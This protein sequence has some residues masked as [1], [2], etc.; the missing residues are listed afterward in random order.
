MFALTVLDHIRL[1]SEHCA[2]NY[3]LHAAAADRLARLAF[4]A[5]IVMATLLAIAV[6]ATIVDLLLTSRYY[7]VAATAAT[8]V[9]AIGFGLYCVFGFEGRV[10]AHRACAQRLWL[11]AERYRSLLTE[12]GEGLVEPP[13]LLTRR[14]GLIADLHAI[15]EHGFAADQRGY[16]AARLAELPA[17]RAA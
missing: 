15:Y 2:R 6:A 3:T 5:R 9:A 14:D 16:E 17:D 13:V 4:A 7:Q 12:V 10:L 8:A 1:D 11:V